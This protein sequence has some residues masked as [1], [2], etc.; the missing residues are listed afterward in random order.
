MIGNLRALKFAPVNSEV[1]WIHKDANVGETEA[2]GKIAVGKVEFSGKD[3]AS[4]SNE[5]TSTQTVIADKEQYL[6]RSLTDFRKLIADV[7]GQLDGGFVFVDDLYQI[8]RDSQPRVLGYLHRLLKDSGIWLK[9]GSIRYATTTYVASDPPVGMQEGHDS[10]AIALDRQFAL[11]GTTKKF[12]ESILHQIA[13]SVDMDTTR[14]FTEGA[15]DRL[16]L[17][18]GGVVRDYLRLAGESIKQAKNRGP[19]TKSGTHRVT[20]EDVNAA[21]GQIAPS[22][23]DDLKLDS[24]HQATALTKLVLDLTEFCR[25]RRSAYFLADSQDRELDEQMRALQHLRFT[26]LLA[27]SE[28]IPDAKS[29]RF[30]VYLL[31]AAQLSA[32]RA[33]QDVDFDGWKDREKRRNRKIIYASDWKPIGPRTGAAGQFKQGSPTAEIDVQETLL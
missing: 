33:T 27:Q 11:Y 22:K 17:A 31:D 19:S 30:N 21:A 4:R 25:D 9:V 14:L 10:H 23:F 1:Q 7:A 20:V 32:Q 26:H 24:P 18:S 6:E 28:T 3:R 16:M 8:S 29:Q 2:L 13:A 15:M 5:V 12:L